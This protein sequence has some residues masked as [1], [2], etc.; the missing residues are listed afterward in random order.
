MGGAGSAAAK[1]DARDRG[2]DGLR[3]RP[4]G[5]ADP[6]EQT[7]V[8]K[9]WLAALPSHRVDELYG[10]TELTPVTERTIADRQALARELES[11]RERGYATSHGESENGVGSTGVA[12]LDPAGEPHAAMS[13]AL[14]LDR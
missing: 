11:I 14:P 9:A 10:R 2:H 3:G 5:C 12:V 13:V 4:E 1:S 8:G 6:A 7:S